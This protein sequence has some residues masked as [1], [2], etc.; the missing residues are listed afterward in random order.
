VPSRRALLGV[1]V[2]W[3]V[4]LFVVQI[5]ERLFLIGAA[6]RLKSPGIGAL[7]TTMLAGARAD[8]IM[9][10]LG[11]VVALPTAA[12]VSRLVTLGPS[13][14]AGHRAPRALR[15]TFTTASWGL[16]ILWG[17]SGAA[18]DDFNR[19]SAACARDA[20]PAYGI[21]IEDTYRRCLAGRG[22][23]RA[24]QLDPPPPGWYRGIE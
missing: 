11:V 23:V 3:W 18:L 12:L 16:T 20:S 15:R 14:R 6:A 5:A 8:L 9:A 19:D 24:Q 22:W 7:G 13:P 4:L 10:S 2:L 1:I 17:K 21:V